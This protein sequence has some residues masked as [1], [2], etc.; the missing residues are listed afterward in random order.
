MLVV[1]ELLFITVYQWLLWMLCTTFLGFGHGM[2]WA[3]RKLVLVGLWIE[4]AYRHTV[5]RRRMRVL[6]MDSQMES[7]VTVH[8]ANDAAFEG[9][10][11]TPPVTPRAWLI[12]NSHTSQVLTLQGE[13]PTHP[14]SPSTYDA[15]TDVESDDECGYE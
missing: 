15:D 14:V 12:T 8:D 3:S 13:L 9:Y 11:E 10:D 2:Y 5:R 6:E 1:I 7:E 4:T